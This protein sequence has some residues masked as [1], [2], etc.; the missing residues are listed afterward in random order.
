[1]KLSKFGAK[2]LGES[3]ILRL[4]DDLGKAAQIPGVR[5][6]GGGNPAQIPQV[7]AI[8][9]QAMERLLDSDNEFE[10]MVGN[11]SGPEGDVRFLEALAD[12]F[13]AEC[14]WDVGPEHIAI[15]NSSQTAFFYL[16][17]LF[18]GT[19]PDGVHRKILLPLAPEY[20]GYVDVGIEPGIFVSHRP[21]IEFLPDRQ[22]KYH[23]D[24]DHLRVTPDIGAICVSRPTNPTGN[25]LTQAELAKLGEL[26][27]RHQ[28]PF[29]V[30]NA[31]GAPFPEII[32]TD[33]GLH[34]EPH[35][36]LTMSLSKLGLPGARTGIVVAQPEIIRAIIAMNAILSLAPGNFGPAL[37]LELVRSREILRMSREIIRPHYR[38]KAEH[39]LA[40]I[41]ESLAGTDYYVHRPEGAFFVWLWFRDL[42]ITAQE[43]YERLKARGVV[44]VPGQYFF[45]GLEED[46]RHKQECIRVSYAADPQIVRQGIQIIGEE[47]RRAYGA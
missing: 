12:L 16:F 29:I 10:R 13:R 24:F 38:E 42:P 4:M 30:D 5:M 35:M 43:L 47:V 23:V 39:A 14:G 11:Y 18:A 33:T 7:H 28:I 40:C 31:Y 6:L 15:T 41:H 9:R 3:G 17:N 36:V 32:Y 1:M 44:V 21:T 45:P 20:I 8:L 27:R 37:T 22:F 34:W 19:G 2:F 46:W 25:V 26:A